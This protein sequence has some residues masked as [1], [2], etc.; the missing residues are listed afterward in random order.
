M[1]QLGGKRRHRCADTRD[2]EL[3]FRPD[4]LFSVLFLRETKE[5]P[6][7]VKDLLTEPWKR[8]QIK[9]ITQAESGSSGPSLS[10]VLHS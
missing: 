2:N 7:R 6:S 5:A 10:S 3:I 1:F 9:S 8:T 4:E